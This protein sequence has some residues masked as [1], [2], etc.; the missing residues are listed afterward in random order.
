MKFYGYCF[1]GSKGIKKK[2]GEPV[3]DRCDRIEKS[4][5]EFCPYGGVPHKKKE[6]D[7]IIINCESDLR[8]HLE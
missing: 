6:I 1:C 2:D 7:D 4:M 3:C 5:T 8:M